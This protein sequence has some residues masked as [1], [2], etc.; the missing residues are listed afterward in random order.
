MP[1]IYLDGPAGKLE[2]MYHKAENP[3]APTAL[4]LHPNPL[5]GGT[6]NNKITY[7]LYKA[8]VNNGFS[9]LRINFRGVGCSGGKF[10]NGI[11]E[12]EDVNSTLDWLRNQNP[13]S[14]H[15]WLAGFS[16]GAFVAMQSIMRR[17]EVENFILVSPPVSRYKCHFF[18]PCPISGLIIQGSEDDISKTID[19]EALVQSCQKQK[20][21]R[22]LYEC[23]QGADHFFNE[24]YI[25][26]FD[27]IIHNYIQNSINSKIIK[28]LIKVRKRMKNKKTSSAITNKRF[29]IV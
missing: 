12:L 27:E 28:P 6:M 18:S 16:F 14:S 8:F 4:V 26:D 10:A 1:K 19:T 17:P 20:S 9:V 15:Y 11:G 25:E 2:G 23:I 22:V 29:N 7:H 13:Q 24:D 3:K 5:Y 21:I